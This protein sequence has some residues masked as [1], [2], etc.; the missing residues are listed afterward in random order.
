MNFMCLLTWRM[1]LSRYVFLSWYMHFH[2]YACLYVYCISV[3][4]VVMRGILRADSAPVGS[5]DYQCTNSLVQRLHA[6][7]SVNFRWEPVDQAIRACE[8][9]SL[10]TDPAVRSL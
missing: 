7:P 2:M 5:S 10:V 6:I 4:S 1:C 9:P 3:V 8:G